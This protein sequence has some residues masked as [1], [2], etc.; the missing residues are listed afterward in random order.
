[1]VKACDKTEK[2][3]SE[4]TSVICPKFEELYIE[5]GFHT[6]I[7]LSELSF[8]FL[9]VV[10]DDM[11]DQEQI[12]RDFFQNAFIN[13]IA[14]ILPKLSNK[15]KSKTK[16]TKPVKKPTTKPTTKKSKKVR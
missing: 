14:D 5:D 13:E 9:N 2:M 6:M 11:N 8:K 12:T 10:I 1:M 4:F 16:K 15:Q 7:A 3:I